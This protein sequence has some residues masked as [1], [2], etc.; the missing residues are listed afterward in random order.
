MN[1]PTQSKS[2]D[3]GEVL[4][5]VPS[6]RI[7]PQ[8][9]RIL[10]AVAGIL[11]FCAG[12]LVGLL[13]RFKGSK[14]S[15]PETGQAA[16]LPRVTIAEVK[17]APPSLDL[18]LP[19]SV[20]A[21]TEATIFS[22]VD[23]YVQKRLA[24]IGD[25]VVAGQVL[26]EIASPETDQLLDQARAALLQAK[27][28]TTQADALLLQARSNLRLAEVTNARAK[29]LSDIG[30]LA[31]QEGD[32]KAAAHEARKADVAA[33]EAGV[34]VYEAAVAAAE[35]N[36]RRLIQVQSFQKVKAPF[37]GVV[38]ARGV[39]LGSLVSAGSNTSVHELFRVAQ[40]QRLRVFVD[41]PQSEAPGIHPGQECSLRV[42]EFKERVFQARVVRTAKSLDGTSRTMQ[43]EID[44]AN[45]DGLVLPGMYAQA[46][47]VVKRPR[48]SLVIP[49][50]ALVGTE[51][52]EE[53]VLIRDGRV[54]RQHVKI[55]RDDGSEV[56]IV[57]GV[58]EGDK[59]V[60]NVSEA[61]REGTRVTVVER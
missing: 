34:R 29:K 6:A 58:V 55:G 5:R 21:G 11:L 16:A 22:R 52:G 47:F 25:R 53:I 18:V 60:T 50:S 19:G 35:A 28:A 27:A 45:A 7:A 4:V 51:N 42:P 17:R 20:K 43:T 12:L 13:P 3:S 49:A 37:D 40:I 10:I 59:V 32:E 9:G 61:L 30:V 56:E 8:P 48:P 41:V 54:H 26:A 57:S 23:G 38:T 14:G 36:V 31:K 33:A 15:S 1:G 39:D 24:D 46:R 2:R 44:L